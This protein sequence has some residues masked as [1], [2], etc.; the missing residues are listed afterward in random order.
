MTAGLDILPSS[1]P[2]VTRG[3]QRINGLDHKPI[4]CANCGAD[5]GWVPEGNCNFAFYLCQ[6]CYDVYGVPAA[7]MA[8]PDVVFWARVKQEQIA[9]CGR[10]LTAPE[11]VEALKD[12]D[13]PLAKLARDRFTFPEYQRR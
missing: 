6:P 11:V 7:M 8:E 9:R 3:V 12:G 13:H 4:F 10:E 5:G 2:R 1:I